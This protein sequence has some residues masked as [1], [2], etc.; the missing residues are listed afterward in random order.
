MLGALVDFSNMHD[1]RPPYRK[2]PPSGS[3]TCVKCV[4]G[5]AGEDSETHYC[6]EMFPRG[7]IQR[8]EEALIEDPSRQM[9][10]RVWLQRNCLF[11]TNPNPLILLFLL[12]IREIQV[13]TSHRGAA[14]YVTKYITHHGSKSGAPGAVGEKQIDV[15]HARAQE[16]GTG[17]KAALAYLL[18]GQV[19][20]GAMCQLEVCHSNLHPQR[21]ISIHDIH[22]VGA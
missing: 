21:N 13:C 18:N 9:L 22:D 20:P 15:R 6:S 5:A 8:G 17:D 10:F 3:H 12:A 4:G 16:E 2:G 11:V 14:K 19:A 7:R 1:W